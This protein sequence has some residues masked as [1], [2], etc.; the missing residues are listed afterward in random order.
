M[1]IDNFTDNYIRSVG[2]MSSAAVKVWA[3]LLNLRWAMIAGKF[4]HT[5]GFSDMESHV[6][7]LF[8]ENEAL[9]GDLIG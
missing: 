5:K 1:S 9:V 8:E 2:G 7:N 4:A 3:D 6:V